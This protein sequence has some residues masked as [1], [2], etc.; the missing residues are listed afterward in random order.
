MYTHPLDHPFLKSIRK[1]EIRNLLSNVHSSTRPRK[2]LFMT[3]DETCVIVPMSVRNV[4]EY[5]EYFL[6]IKDNRYECFVT[7]WTEHERFSRKCSPDTC[8]KV[9]V[10]D[11][12]QKAN[13]SICQYENVFDSTIPEMGPVQTGCLFSPLR[14]SM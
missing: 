10:V 13:R 11:G 12:H 7:F 14:D 1:S 4:E 2:F 3:T 8:S 5:S 6:Q 9:F